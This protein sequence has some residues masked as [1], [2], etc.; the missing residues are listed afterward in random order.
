MNAHPC[1]NFSVPAGIKTQQKIVNTINPMMFNSLDIKPFG[2]WPGILTRKR[3]HRQR[4]AA[5]DA[6]RARIG[7]RPVASGANHGR[8][9][10]R[11]AIGRSPEMI[12]ILDEFDK[13]VIG[14]AVLLFHERPHR[15]GDEQETVNVMLEKF[16]V[17]LGLAR[18]VFGGGG[19]GER[20]TAGAKISANE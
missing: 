19:S 18:G 9:F 11:D 16:D 13:R 15:F 6:K 1:Q 7:I 10:A 5:V 14:I 2:V 17:G 20:I 4:F 3:I 12:N 8:I